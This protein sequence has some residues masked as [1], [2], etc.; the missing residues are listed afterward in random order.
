[1]SL[2]WRRSAAIDAGLSCRWDDDDDE[3]DDDADELAA[4]NRKES[5]QEFGRP[6]VCASIYLTYT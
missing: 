1:M 2:L 6:P 5:S 3:D 4:N